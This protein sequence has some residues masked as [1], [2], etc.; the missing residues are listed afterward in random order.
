MDIILFGD[1]TLRD[2]LI[3]F[4]VLVG[5]WILW[6]VLKKIFQ[7][8]EGSRHVQAVRCDACDWE[9]RVSQYAGRCPRCNT[10]LGDRRTRSDL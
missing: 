9:G 4:F 8:S 3:V 1:Y 2:S 10:P 7:K 6:R 5:V